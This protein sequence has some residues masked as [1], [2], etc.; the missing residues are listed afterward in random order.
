MR[1]AR[2]RGAVVIVALGLVL[3]PG[4]RGGR[5]PVPCPRT[6]TPNLHL[7]VA[8]RAARG[9]RIEVQLDGRTI[10]NGEIAG[11]HSAAPVS[12]RATAG[13]HRMTTRTS[14]GATHQA[15]IQCER[16]KWVLVQRDPRK[17]EG[18]AVHITEYPQR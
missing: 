9:E 3:L 12:L 16:E 1:I 4:C 6:E 8:N 11:G 15:M 18:V 14:G 13:W 17:P 10:W 5:R 2:W 7:R